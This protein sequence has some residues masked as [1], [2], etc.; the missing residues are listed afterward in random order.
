MLDF[1]QSES[2]SEVAQSCPTL[3]DPWTVAHQAPLSMGY[4]RQEY[5]SESSFPSPG[6]EPESPASLALQVDS[7]PLTPKAILITHTQKEPSCRGP[8]T[9]ASRRTLFESDCP[10]PVSHIPPPEKFLVAAQELCRELLCTWREGLQTKSSS[11]P[12]SGEK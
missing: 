2:E 4:S 12:L 6:T 10:S 11:S 5:W 8:F 7:L 9:E 1:G 3:C